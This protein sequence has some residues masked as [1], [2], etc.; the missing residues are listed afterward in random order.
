MKTY[1]YFTACL[2]LVCINN[3]S[4]TAQDEAGNIFQVIN[5]HDGRIARG[6]PGDRK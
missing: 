6:R 4:I 1:I 3:D 5:V 2:I